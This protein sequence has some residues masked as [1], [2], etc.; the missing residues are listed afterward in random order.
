M[1]SHPDELDPGLLARLGA[2][3]AAAL[4]AYRRQL[5]VERSSVE[6][7]LRALA[8]QPPRRHSHARPRGTY[9]LLRAYIQHLGEKGTAD[10]ITAG[11]AAEWMLARGWVTP[12]PDPRKAA[13]QGLGTLARY[14][15]LEQVRTGH[16]QIPPGELDE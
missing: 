13:A 9:V 11:P 12:A 1:T 5:N 3:A 8:R 16:Y 7:A 15:E 4:R 6:A 10:D 14:G 2:E